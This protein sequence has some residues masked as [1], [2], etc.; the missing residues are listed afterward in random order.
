MRNLEKEIQ[1]V[2][3][4][5][6]ILN[7]CMRIYLENREIINAKKTLKDIQLCKHEL[8][9]LI[10]ARVEVMDAVKEKAKDAVQ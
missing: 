9:K 2:N 8:K 3:G 7:K 4:I 1:A 10:A 6:N 5:I